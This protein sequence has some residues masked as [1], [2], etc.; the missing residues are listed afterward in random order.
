MHMNLKNL[1]KIGDISRKFKSPKMTSEDMENPNRPFQRNY[2]SC[3]KV[4][5]IRPR[6]YHEY[7]KPTKDFK[8]WKI[9]MLLK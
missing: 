3:Q 1:N 5:G 9:P 2:K 6:L 7:M 8:E 4:V